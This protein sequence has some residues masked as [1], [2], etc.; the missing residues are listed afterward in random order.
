[1]N[2]VSVVVT[3]YKRYDF[4][5]RAVRSVMSQ[6]APTDEV[7][8]V[9]DSP[10][11]LSFSEDRIRK[12]SCESP[13]LGERVVRG[14]QESTKDFIFFLE[15][16]DEFREGKIRK[17]REVIYST[18]LS[19]AHNLQQYID[20]SG[21][22]IP[23]SDRRVMIYEAFQPKGYK[24]WKDEEGLVSLWLKFPSLHHNMS[25]IAVRR[26]LVLPN[27][28]VLSKMWSSIDWAITALSYKG[29][30][31][32][33]ERLTSYR[34]GSGTA[35]VKDKGF[36]ELERL[37]KVYERLLESKKTFLKYAQI[38]PD[39]EEFLKFDIYLHEA[40]LSFLHGKEFGVDLQDYI[41]HIRFRNKALVPFELSMQLS[42][43]LS[44]RLYRLES[45]FIRKILAALL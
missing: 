24:H 18:G 13:N 45:L 44:K 33:P 40:Y 15:D 9:A 29:G 12:V 42:L 6:L 27:E 41:K 35:S 34:V 25:S 10:E 7:I 38:T 20:I 21:H 28:D 39:L 5:E 2:G 23:R 8:I 31:H 22:E 11:N 43:R 30:A 26:D 3:V 4:V 19:Y 37:I 36:R 14:V 16:D 17:V 32:V 1:M